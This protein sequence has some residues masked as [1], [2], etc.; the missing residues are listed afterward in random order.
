M[1]TLDR[2]STPAYRI[3]VANAIND[4]DAVLEGTWVYANPRSGAVV[5]FRIAGEE[6][7]LKVFRQQAG[8]V[9]PLKSFS[10]DVVQYGRVIDLRKV[11]GANEIFKGGVLI[12]ERLTGDT[13]RVTSDGQPSITF[14]RK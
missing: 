11:D 7:D 5:V 3:D 8:K 1:G 13:I 9:H 12:F 6:F 4:D 10:G 14:K 2:D